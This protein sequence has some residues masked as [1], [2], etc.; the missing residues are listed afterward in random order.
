MQAHGCKRKWELNAKERPKGALECGSAAAA[1]VLILAF[2]IAVKAAAVR[3]TSG[4]EPHSKGFAST[5]KLCGIRQ[6]V[7][8][9][10]AVF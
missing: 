9:F 10:R 8:T 4:A 3:R 7:S 6:D 1:F 2:A 5:I